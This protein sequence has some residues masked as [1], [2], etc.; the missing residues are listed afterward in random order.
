MLGRRLCTSLLYPRVARDSLELLSQAKKPTKHDASSGMWRKLTTLTVCPPPA[1]ISGKHTNP[2]DGSGS[3][4]T[5]DD[6]VWVPAER[7]TKSEKYRPGLAND[8]RK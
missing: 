5:E 7:V 6:C 4:A 8:G 3:T 1:S 2:E